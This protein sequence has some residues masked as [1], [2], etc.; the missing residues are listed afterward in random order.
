MNLTPSAKNIMD[1]KTRQFLGGMI[2]G[3]KFLDITGEIYKKDLE[4]QIN[5]LID[6][7][8]TRIG[9]IKNIYNLEGKEVIL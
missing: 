2:T 6:V 1:Y 7:G 4:K 9:A 5:F 8:Y 3:K